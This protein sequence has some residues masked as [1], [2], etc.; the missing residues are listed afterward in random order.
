MNQ[1]T[2]QAS[3]WLS[4]A[5]WDACAARGAVVCGA[6]V[7]C[8]ARPVSSTTDTTALVGVYPDA[9]GPGFDVRVAAFL[10][11]D[12]LRERTT[13][14]R[15]PYDEWARRGVLIATPGNVVD[16]E[17]V[18]AELQAWAAESDVREVAY[19]PWNATDLVQRLQ[20]QDG[21]TCVPMRQ[22]F[23]SLTRADQGAREGRAVAGAAPR[24]AS[25]AA[26]R[27]SATSRSR[28]TA[29]AT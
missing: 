23:A 9:D 6:A 14:D 17:R 24:R 1:W 22:G 16:Y 18:R 5:Q 27:I 29:P 8:R 21:F 25:G 28:P 2:E 15:L 12:K 7:L 4:L 11:A 3:R 19:D 13:R 26:R 20:A 10:P